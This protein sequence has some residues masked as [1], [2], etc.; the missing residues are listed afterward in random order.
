MV[1][2]I[3]EITHGFKNQGEKCLVKH[4]EN[5][6]NCFLKTVPKPEGGKHPEGDKPRQL[7]PSLFV[8][9]LDQG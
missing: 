7:H 5:L 4:I 8:S 3:P 6:A 9:F 1:S 2:I